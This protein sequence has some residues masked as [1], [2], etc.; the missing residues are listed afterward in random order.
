MPVGGVDEV[1]DENLA[2]VRFVLFHKEDSANHRSNA[3]ALVM[4]GCTGKGAGPGD[5]TMADW[6]M[7]VAAFAED[8]FGAI[9]GFLKGEVIGGD[10]LLAS[11]KSLFGDGELVHK[12]EA[13]VAFF[14]TEIHGQEAAGILL[15]SLPTDHLAQAGCVAGPLDARQLLEKVEE[16]R[17]IQPQ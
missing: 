6:V 14:G 8:P 2:G 17:L 13:E 1:L 7:N 5:V 10:V 3:L 4:V 12:G 16:N 11:G 9:V 15:G